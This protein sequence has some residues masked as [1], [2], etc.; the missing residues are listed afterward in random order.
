[1]WVRGCGSPWYWGGSWSVNLD[2][3]V[4]QEGAS[5]LRLAG[6]TA[7]HG[8]GRRWFLGEWIRTLRITTVN[9]HRRSQ[10]RHVTAILGERGRARHDGT[11]PQRHHHGTGAQQATARS[12]PGSGWQAIGRDATHGTC[13]S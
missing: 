7:E 12:T 1:M 5:V 11:Q 10:L 2:R 9:D 4:E 6:Q 3:G 8:R 13:S